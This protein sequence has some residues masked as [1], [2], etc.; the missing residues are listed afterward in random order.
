MY[1]EL[2]EEEQAQ[3][4]IHLSNSKLL[5]IFLFAA[6]VCGACFGSG[7]SMGKHTTVKG[8][9][10]LAAVSTEATAPPAATRASATPAAARPSPRTL[11]DPSPTPSVTVDESASVSAPAAAQPAP[12]PVRLP[13]PVATPVT[14]AVV[15]KTETPEPAPIAAPGGRTYIVQ[16][17]AVSHPGDANI[18]VSA[19]H[20]KGYQASAVPSPQ[21]SLTHVQ[22][23]PFATQKDAATMRDRLSAD[24]YLAI[25]K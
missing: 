24:G 14:K 3:T 2:E 21:D 19:L 10:P 7:Y 16:V 5:M 9:L 18:L 22:V 23:G 6:V 17:A 20:R 13:R 25:V 11:A 1:D 12:I 8:G 15:V 4:E